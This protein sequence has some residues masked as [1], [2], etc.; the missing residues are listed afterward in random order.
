M[1]SANTDF[2]STNL[3]SPPINVFG[4]SQNISKH[5]PPLQVRAFYLNNLLIYAE[6]YSYL[7]FLATI[8]NSWTTEDHL[9]CQICRSL[10]NLFILTQEERMEGLQEPDGSFLTED[11]YRLQLRLY[12]CMIKY[13]R[14][15]SARKRKKSRSD[16]TYG[17]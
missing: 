13:L 2:C 4:W 3:L 12:V 10:F 5:L 1:I 9:S 11:V 7:S 16:Y 15:I 17:H 6:T 8:W 14:F